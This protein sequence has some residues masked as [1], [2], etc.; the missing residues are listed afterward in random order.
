M[1]S[2]LLAPILAFLLAAASFPELFQKAKQ[3]FKLGSYERALAT[4]TSLDQESSKQGFEKQRAALLPGLL[5]Y[6]AASLAGLGREKEAVAGFEAF[7]TLKPDTRLDP[8]LYSKPV[9][10]ALEEAR[11]EIAKS[12]SAAVQTEAGAIA[13]AYKAFVLPAGHRDESTNEDWSEGPVR[14]LLTAPESREYSTLADPVS[15]SEFIAN[16]WKARD[17]VPETVE[18]EFREEFERRVAFADA[19]F[20]QDETRGSLTDRG[21]VLILLGPPSYNGRKPLRTGDDVADASGLSR[22]T[23]SEIAAAAQAGGSNTQRVQRIDKVTGAGTT[24]EDATANWIEVWHYLRRQ[25]PRVIPNQ[26]LEFEFVT[27]VGY[28]KNVLQREAKVLHA[29]ERVKKTARRGEAPPSS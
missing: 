6:R 13:A 18:N 1:A 8:A 21:M 23:H 26:E 22:Y 4:L 12:Q 15:R 17:S 14:W 27:K 11:A 20:A 3:E 28:G 9:I 24:V 19:H 10:A 7:L 5:F 25:L 2:P 16:F 29:I